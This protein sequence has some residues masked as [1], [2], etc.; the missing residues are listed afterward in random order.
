MLNLYNNHNGIILVGILFLL[1]MYYLGKKCSCTDINK[2]TCIRK[3]FYGVQLSHLYFFIIL[4]FLFPSYFFTIQLYGA[5]F[6]AFEYYLDKND[7]IVKKYIGGCLM[8]KPNNVSNNDI[9]N[10][11]VYRNIPKYLNP[12]DKF[13]GIKNSTLHGWHGSV[14]EIVV[15]IIGFIIGYILNIIVFKYFINKKN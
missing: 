4:G 11:T 5:L 13:F 12:I 15:N 3:E 8:N 2:T 9:S 7:E 10:Y 1:A 14:A 6:E